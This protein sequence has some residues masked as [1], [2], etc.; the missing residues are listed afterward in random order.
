MRWCPEMTFLAKWHLTVCTGGLAVGG[1]V[2]SGL[3]K[4]LKDGE[5]SYW[6]PRL[7]LFGLWTE[8]SGR[9]PCASP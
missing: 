5:S 6:A 8:G 3:F 2:E 1:R 9:T 7:A 4:K